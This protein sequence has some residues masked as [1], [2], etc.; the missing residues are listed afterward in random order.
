VNLVERSVG[1]D[2]QGAQTG[3]EVKTLAGFRQGL[4][5]CMT[6]RADAL[7]G[8]SES[9]TSWPGRVSRRPPRRT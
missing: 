8:L 1:G 6:R 3:E 7:F 2:S 5:A 9:E 4:Y